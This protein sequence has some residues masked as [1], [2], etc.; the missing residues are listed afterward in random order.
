MAAIDQLERDIHEY[1]ISSGSTQALQGML[2][3][4]ELLILKYMPAHYLHDAL[5]RNQLY[6]SER[7]GF[8]W[9]DAI[10]VSPAVYPRTTMMYGDVG[11]VGTYAASGRRFYDADNLTGVRYYQEWITHQA[12]PYRELTTTVHANSANRSLR[13]DFRTRFQIDCVYFRP[14][15]DCAN[16]VDAQSDWWLAITHWDDYGNVGSG[17]SD[18]VA[19]LKWC[20]VSPDSFEQTGRGYQ[21]ALHTKL[22]SNRKFISGHYTGLAADLRSV[23]RSSADQV[24]ICDFA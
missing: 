6:A 15:E 12:G 2:E 22:T 4:D 1:I 13:N 17:Y 21:P 5:T 19:N 18:A 10:Y 7:V 3:E 24:I 9:G 14:D 8:T 23:Y 11:V 20:V 16:Y